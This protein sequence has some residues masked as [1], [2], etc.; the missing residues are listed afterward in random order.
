MSNASQVYEMM[1]IPEEK[2]EVRE[3]MRHW[4]WSEME[5]TEQMTL[6]KTERKKI[7]QQISKDWF[8]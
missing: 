3:R 5:K 2:H 8:S 1:S 7:Q 6:M 4:D